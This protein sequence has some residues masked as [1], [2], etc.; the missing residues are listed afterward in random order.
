MS[1][2]KESANKRNKYGQGSIRRI[3]SGK[4]EYRVRY[5]DEFDRLKQKSFSCDTVEECLARAKE[6]KQDLRY[7]KGSQESP[8][9]TE[10]F[11][12]LP[13]SKRMA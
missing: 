4:Y 7:K 13:S 9:M 5:Q 12:R 1:S 8:D 6:F 2:R 3:K 11:R 10:I